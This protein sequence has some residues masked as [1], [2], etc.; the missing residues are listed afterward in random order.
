VQET[1]D[2]QTD[3]IVVIG[4]GRL[5]IALVPSADTNTE[6]GPE[7]TEQLGRPLL[8]DGDKPKSALLPYC[9]GPGG[10]IIEIV[11]FVGGGLYPPPPFPP[12]QAV[13]SKKKNRDAEK[14]LKSFRF[15]IVY[16][17]ARD[18][19]HAQ[20]KRAGSAEFRLSETPRLF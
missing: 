8:P 5:Y 1:A 14:A 18:R 6:P 9:T 20:H 7:V 17:L 12:P 11:G 19:R 4:S 3:I 16:P 10:G 2:A 13:N 15:F